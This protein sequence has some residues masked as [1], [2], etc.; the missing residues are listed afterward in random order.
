M[1]YG[2]ITET[3]K[4]NKLNGLYDVKLV[5]ETDTNIISCYRLL[6]STKLKWT[7]SPGYFLLSP[8]SKYIFINNT[9]DINTLIKNIIFSKN[10]LNYSN[11]ELLEINTDPIKKYTKLTPIDI[12]S[13]YC[14]NLALEDNDNDRNYQ[15]VN[16]GIYNKYD[17]LVKNITTMNNNT[18]TNLEPKKST[19]F[20]SMTYYLTGSPSQTI[21]PDNCNVTNI[22]QDIDNY[23]TFYV[24]GLTSLN[25][26]SIIIIIL[27]I[28]QIIQDSEKL[29]KKSNNGEFEI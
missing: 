22:Y 9:T 5:S 17:C 1:E 8:D 29:K 12:P 26:I 15:I 27:L 23:N 2:Y 19:L 16:K 20:E 25:F 7:N 28:V 11:E 3:P 18:F 13:E 10:N 4:Y 24:Y 14:I 21:D 6:N